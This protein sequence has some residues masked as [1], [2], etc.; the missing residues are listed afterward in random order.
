MGS[1]G[2]YVFKTEVLNE[3]LNKIPGDDF[4]KNIIPAAMEAGYVHGF[5]FDNFWEDIGTMR[6]F[7]EVNLL[8]AQEA[9]SF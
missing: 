2:I 9:P 8:M 1:M 3:L 5:V 6:R 4:G 7:Y